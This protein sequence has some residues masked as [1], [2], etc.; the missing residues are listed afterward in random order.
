MRYSVPVEGL[1]ELQ[2]FNYNEAQDDFGAHRVFDRPGMEDGFQVC[3]W[4]PEEYCR[5]FSTCGE[6]SA[7]PRCG[8]KIIRNARIRNVGKSQ[9]CMV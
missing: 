1:K 2:L 6:C 8:R 9:S 4:P 7:D 5:R 3:V